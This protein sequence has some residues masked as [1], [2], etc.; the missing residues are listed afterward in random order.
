MIALAA[1]LAFVVV[2]GL[3]GGWLVWQ[4]S[5][6]G[7][8]AAAAGDPDTLNVLKK[9]R[10]TAADVSTVDPTALFY[11]G[12]KQMVTQPLLHLTQESYTEEAEY[13]QGE[14]GY[15]W[16]S[17][18][19]YRT[20]KFRMAWG[21]A[22][23]EDPITVCRDGASYG[24]SYS[25]KRWDG[26][27]TGDSLCRL[28]SAYRY[29][30]DGIS[31]GGMTQAQA[32]R[33]IKEL[34]NDYKGFVKP[35][36]LRLTEVKGRQYLRLV[37]G[38]TPVKRADDMYYGGQSLMWSFKKTGLDPQSHPYSYTGGMGTGFHA[39]YYLDPGSLL[40]A[41]SE[42]EVTPALG[43][44]GRPREDGDFYKVRVEYHHPA[45]LPAMKPEGSP[46]RPELT[47]P[48]DKA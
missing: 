25:L 44:D 31:T 40:T 1:V 10:L 27:D 14:P 32:D 45:R 43:K 24:F 12:F 33:W 48:R 9:G 11:A 29:I 6:D 22:D 17:G 19:D 36:E 28:K 4:N 21:S 13:R 38:Y 7:G 46:A 18:F 35:G 16:E 34:Q 30:S 15:V 5:G 26:P 2:L 41:Y 20:K 23:A 3:G 39:V 42:V 37:V 8:D 47:W